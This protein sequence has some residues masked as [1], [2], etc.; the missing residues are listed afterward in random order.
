MREKRRLDV[1]VEDAL[2]GEDE[3]L[4]TFGVRF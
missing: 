3:K 1:F 4:H 2:L